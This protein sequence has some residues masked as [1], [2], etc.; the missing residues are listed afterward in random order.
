MTSLDDRLFNLE[1]AIAEIS[2]RVM[3]NSNELGFDDGSMIHRRLQNS[4]E[5]ALLA[6]DAGDTAWMLMA[7]AL[8]LL[9]TIPGLALYY[10]GMVE[11]KNVL[12]TAMQSFSITC[13][14]TFLWLCLGYSL[15]FAPIDQIRKNAVIGDAS[16]FWLKGIDLYSY[17]QLATTIPESVYVVYQMTFAIITPAL[18]VGSFGD[19][20]KYGSL[21]IFVTLWHI[22]VYCPIAHANWHPAGCLFKLGVLDYAGGNV[23][24]IA[25]GMSGLATTVLLGKRK[26][27]GVESFEPHNILL[28]F[29]GASML[30]FGWFGF[31]AGSAVGAGARAG[32]AMM[33]T[34]I[35]T[36][37]AAI[38]WMITE[39]FYRKPSLLGMISGAI[40]G[41]VAITPGCGFVDPTG[42]FVIGFL[43]GPWCYYCARL[44]HYFGYDDALDAFGVHA[45]GGILGGILV[46]LFARSEID[47][48]PTGGA[49]YGSHK[50]WQI[51]YQV[52][53][54]GLSAGWA[55]VVTIIIVLAIDK[56]IGFRVSEKDEMAGLDES[57]HGETVGGEH[58]NG[59]PAMAVQ[60]LA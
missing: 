44:K 55:L 31:N 35:S 3:S 24:H 13:L 2:A 18:V 4:T 7:S 45:T 12:A 17:N 25:S 32:M 14:V 49:F 59:R 26:G 36:G 11:K 1:H 40:S 38:T 39:S 34:Q 52:A 54:C 48:L 22:F 60:S 57:I 47:G 37:T 43:A 33:A 42:A 51:A 50:G 28:S 10:G 23:V 21:M 19:R 20:V 46:G 5:S 15:S 27:F 8:V 41:L 29:I 9:M 53:G 30:W 56:T 6:L 58:A 16:R